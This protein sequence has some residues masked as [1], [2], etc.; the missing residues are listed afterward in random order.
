MKTTLKIQNLKCSGCAN[1]ITKTLSV[2]DIVTDVHVSNNSNT[3]SFSHNNEDDILEI[4]EILIKLGYPAVGDKNVFTT[5][6]KSYVS[7][8]IGRVNTN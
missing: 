2:I 4:K 1:T 6:T 5:K 8:A 7:C 3:V